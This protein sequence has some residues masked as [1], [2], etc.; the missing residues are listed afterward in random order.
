[1]PTKEKTCLISFKSNEEL[2]MKLICETKTPNVLYFTKY[3]EIFD[4]DEW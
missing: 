4:S 3:K 2:E 1:M